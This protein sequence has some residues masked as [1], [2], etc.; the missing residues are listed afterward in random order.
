M[1]RIKD[2]GISVSY[3]NDTHVTMVFGVD[4][5]FTDE[6]VQ[7]GRSGAATFGADCVIWDEDFSSDD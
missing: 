2:T 1:A 3:R 4:I 5:E 7:E 6:E